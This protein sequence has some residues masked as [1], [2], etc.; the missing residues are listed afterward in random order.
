ML[1]RCCWLASVAALLFANF[2]HAQ[3]VNLTEA[4]LESRCVRNEI[5]MQLEGKITVKQDG[6]DLT[7]P[8]KAEAKHVY[9]ERFLDAP[10]NIAGKVARHYVTAEGVITFNNND[11]SKR[12]L[13]AD[14]RFLVAQRVSGQVVS[15]SPKG[16]LTREE[17]E[18]SEHFDTMA[19]A[20]LLPGKTIE[21]GK[22][23]MLPNAVVLALC[24][25]DGVTA[26][27]LQGTL[28]SVKENIAV[29]KIAGKANG[30]N[31]GAEVE[32]EINARFE[33]DVKLQRIVAIQ[34]KESDKRQQGPITPALVADVIINL[35]RTP[36]AEP[37]ELNKAAL[38]NVPDAATPPSRLTNIHHQ[39][40]KKRFELS[41]P[42]DWYVTS[43]EYSSQLVMRHIE[44]GD[45]IAQ[46]TITPWKKIDPKD[47]M[48]LEKFAEEMLKT[49][50]WVE[51]KETGREKV[52]NPAKGQH[53]VY[54]VAAS[55]Q[56]ESTR[57]VQYFYLIVSPQGEQLIVTF[58][59]VPQHVPRL[60]TRD[61]DFVRE[62]AFP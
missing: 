27:T 39:D 46:V 9:L 61:L 30:I 19:V 44:R 51:E 58:S 34:W 16:A 31:L 15:F 11:S 12:S 14:R 62:I 36:I 18:L 26:Q 17:M 41:H 48:P 13:R 52:K 49:P 59:V 53:T 23:W 40:A 38:A 4:P 1:S 33:F 47:V 7:Y 37:E 35:K 28:E 29:G 8:H 21:V 50:G 55:G 20:G 60:G 57:T 56:L 54:R 2:V 3:S 10:G 43:P 24:E 6:K 45:F 42:R 25:L 22:S 32:M 5:A